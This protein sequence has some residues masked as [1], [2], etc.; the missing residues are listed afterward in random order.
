MK[1]H[2][3]RQNKNIEVKFSGSVKDLLEKIS[4]NPEAVLVVRDSEL[5]TLDRDVSDN[6]EIKLLSVISGG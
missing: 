2:I 3:E 1:V 6:D 5:L 4:V